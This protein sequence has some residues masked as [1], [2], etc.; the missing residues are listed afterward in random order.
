M[1]FQ[2]KENNKN[3][4]WI[5]DVLAK[6]STQTADDTVA[7]E[8]VGNNKRARK[9][10]RIDTFKSRPTAR[11]NS[12]VFGSTGQEGLRSREGSVKNVPI[13]SAEGRKNQVLIQNVLILHRY[14]SNTLDGT[15]TPLSHRAHIFF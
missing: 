1:S 7:C 11:R 15:I 2:Q 8:K 12:I 3:K 13:R 9:S 4:T 6:N 10:R 14:A 5:R